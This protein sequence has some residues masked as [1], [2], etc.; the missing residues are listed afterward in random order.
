MSILLA[1]Y[2]DFDVQHLF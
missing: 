1:I 2:I